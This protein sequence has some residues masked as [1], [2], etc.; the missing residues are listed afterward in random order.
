MITSSITAQCYPLRIIHNVIYT[1]NVI[2]SSPRGPQKQSFTSARR[3][4]VTPASAAD[5]FLPLFFFFVFPPLPGDAF[6]DILR[7]QCFPAALYSTLRLFPFRFQFVFRPLT[8]L[9]SSFVA[10]F[11]SFRGLNAKRRVRAQIND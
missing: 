2:H 10:L 1:L 11:P 9:G 3:T 7:I 6:F 5:R 4:P 8:V